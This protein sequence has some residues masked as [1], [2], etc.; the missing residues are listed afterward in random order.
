[1][2]SMLGLVPFAQTEFGQTAANRLDRI[3]L[4]SAAERPA[5]GNNGEVAIQQ[6]DRRI[7]GRN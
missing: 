1:M 5:G 4:E 2:D 3:N 6:Q 7:G